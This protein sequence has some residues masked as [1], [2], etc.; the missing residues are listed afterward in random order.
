MLCSKEIFLTYVMYSVFHWSEAFDSGF[1]R[2]SCHSSNA[3][4]T[5]DKLGEQEEN[6]TILLLN[7][8]L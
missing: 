6:C 7:F 8:N 1:E 5:R 3:K 4:Q 2:Q